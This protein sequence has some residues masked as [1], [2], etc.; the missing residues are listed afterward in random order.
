[1]YP[2]DMMSPKGGLNY[3]YTLF[4]G[5]SF[6][7]LIDNPYYGWFGVSFDMLTKCD[8]CT[9]YFLSLSYYT[10]A[11]MTASFLTYDTTFPF[12]LAV[13]PS[14]PLN[15]DSTYTSISYSLG[16][17]SYVTCTKSFPVNPTLTLSLVTTT[18]PTSY[19]YNV[20]DTAKIIPVS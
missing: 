18:Y 7:N 5:Y 9:T 12:T 20:D 2:E 15:S 10:V 4:Q 14:Y 11:T 1:M 8:N 19:V 3:F 6:M 17:P 16:T 13:V